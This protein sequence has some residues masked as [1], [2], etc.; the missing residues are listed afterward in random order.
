MKILSLGFMLASTL[1]AAPPGENKIEIGRSNFAA[2]YRVTIDRQTTV[3]KEKLFVDTEIDEQFANEVS[4]LKLLQHSRKHP[5]IVTMLASDNNS[6]E[7]ESMDTDLDQVLDHLHI[8]RDLPLVTLPADLKEG[9]DAYFHKALTDISRALIF[10]HAHDVIHGDVKPGN[11]LLQFK[12]GMLVAKLCDFGMSH[13]K[14]TR[15]KPFGTMAYVAPEAV[16][17]PSEAD[18]S[19]DIWS[20]GNVVG[21]CYAIFMQPTALVQQSAQ[22][23]REN[24]EEFKADFKKHPQK[25]YANFKNTPYYELI[26]QLLVVKPKK[27][28]DAHQLFNKLQEMTQKKSNAE[29]SELSFMQKFLL[30]LHIKKPSDDPEEYEN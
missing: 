1:L 22:Q 12:N 2:V 10:V 3:V 28:I 19:S 27:R 25:Y 16:L 30:S 7:F 20:F 29:S 17:N 14:G 23:N 21:A 4:T 26:Q 13:K 8:N 6:I 11:I 24:F 9:K 15:D 5:F 18:T